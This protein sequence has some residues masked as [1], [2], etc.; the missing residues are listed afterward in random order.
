MYVDKSIDV[1]ACNPWGGH[2]A[3]HQYRGVVGSVARMAAAAVST[4][5]ELTGPTALPN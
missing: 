4:A 2:A 5:G 3:A 1:F